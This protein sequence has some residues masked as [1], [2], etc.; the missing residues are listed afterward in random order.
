MLIHRPIGVR[1]HFKQLLEAKL[2]AQNL[3]SPLPW[4][5]GGWVGGRVG[6]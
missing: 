2:A 4:E 3:L 5:V 1:V 6:G